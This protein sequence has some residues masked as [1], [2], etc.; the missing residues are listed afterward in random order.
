MIEIN[1]TLG[2]A[3][4][5]GFLATLGATTAFGFAIAVVVI[6]FAIFLAS[7]TLRYFRRSGPGKRSLLGP[8]AEPRLILL[9]AATFGNAL[10]YGLLEVGYPAYATALGLPALA[11]AILA[12]NS[13]GSA[14]GGGLFGGL[15]FKAP[16]ERQF[17]CVMALMALPVFLH[18]W[19]SAPVAFGVVAF[20]AGALIAPSIASQSVLVSRLAPAQYATEA[21][22]WSSTFIVGGL[23]SGLA[24][25][26]FLAETVG[27][28][29]VFVTGG[30]VMA[31]MAV[32]AL[33]VTAPRAAK[34][35]RAE[36]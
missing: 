10:C 8:L 3:I 2:P 16:V 33:L 19:V 12:V 4:V 17:A 13:L 28:R 29:S 27:L 24:L 1:F 5:A 18:A 21:F 30:G 7:P 14:I 15:H 20:F 32:V 31:T 22:T 6:A 26:G 36:R 9:F 34:P 25:G 11:G 35:L 23:G